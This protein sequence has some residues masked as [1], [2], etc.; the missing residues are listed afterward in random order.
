VGGVP[1]VGSQAVQLAGGTSR[2][3][4]GQRVIGIFILNTH[5]LPPCPATMSVEASF[6]TSHSSTRWPLFHGYMA[7][8]LYCP[9]SPSRTVE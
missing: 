6:S 4:E 3:E 1:W 5:H 7:P 8:R 9:S 2:S